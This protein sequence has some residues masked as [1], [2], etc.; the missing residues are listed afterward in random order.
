MSAVLGALHRPR[1]CP[2]LGGGASAGGP[3]PGRGGGPC[4]GPVVWNQPQPR[5]AACAMR[6]TAILLAAGPLSGPHSSQTTP[7][8]VQWILPRGAGSYDFENQIVHSS[9]RGR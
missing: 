6:G 1:P 7:L 8:N 5:H 2:R 9:V 3:V 4:R